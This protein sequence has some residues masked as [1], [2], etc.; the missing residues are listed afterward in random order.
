MRLDIIPLEQ[1]LFLLF[2][3]VEPL[4]DLGCTLEFALANLLNVYLGSTKISATPHH[5]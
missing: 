5:R 4:R 3:L 2:D 1:Y